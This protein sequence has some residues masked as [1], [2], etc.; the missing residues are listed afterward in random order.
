MTTT[1]DRVKVQKRYVSNLC[2]GSS[3]AYRCEPGVI[4]PHAAAVD[5]A[6]PAVIFLQ[7]YKT[8]ESDAH[9]LA[10]GS[11]YYPP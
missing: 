2:Y 9:A 3:M 11:I 6:R 10:C 4:Y 5:V 1:K 8:L 7:A